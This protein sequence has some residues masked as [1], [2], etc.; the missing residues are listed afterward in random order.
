LVHRTFPDFPGNIFLDNQLLSVAISSNGNA[1]TG[2]AIVFKKI[3]GTIENGQIPDASPLQQ[4]ADVYFNSYYFLLEGD[5]ENGLNNDR[6]EIYVEPSDTTDPLDGGQAGQ[7]AVIQDLQD[8]PLYQQFN[9]YTHKTNQNIAPPPSMDI[10]ALPKALFDLLPGLLTPQ[11]VN[12]AEASDETHLFA[13]GLEGGSVWTIRQH[14]PVSASPEGIGFVEAIELFQQDAPA[15]TKTTKFVIRILVRAEPWSHYKCR[16]RVKRNVRDVNQDGLSDI[17]PCFEMDSP[18]SPWVDYG[19]QQLTYDY[20]EPDNAPAG[21]PDFLKY[22]A[23][24]TATLSLDDFMKG[25]Y[26]TIKIIS[27]L[28]ATKGLFTTGEVT[29][30]ARNFTMVGSERTA[31][32]LLTSWHPDKPTTDVLALRKTITNKVDRFV[33]KGSCDKVDDSFA[34]MKGLVKGFAPFLLLS[35]Y[36]KEDPTRA[37]LSINWQLKFELFNEN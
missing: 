7:L 8:L 29:S 21:M 20:L 35:W 27:G 26:T 13:L 12:T 32:A 23:I 25:N 16:V 9:Y 10:K 14:A 15:G 24:P 1:G 2:D 5:E 34:G 19:I 30:G 18:Y 4:R 11:A 6:I 3:V 22:L 37:V 36:S 33:Y 28:L 17:N 31:N